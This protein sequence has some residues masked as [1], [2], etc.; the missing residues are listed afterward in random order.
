M[1]SIPIARLAP[2]AVLLLVIG[3]CAHVGQAPISSAAPPREPMPVALRHVAEIRPGTLLRVFTRDGDST[4][5]FF[6][7]MLL[8]LD[9]LLYHPSSKIQ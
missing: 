3:G 2:C 1:I 5:G 4:A 6:L 9:A 8:G 7:G